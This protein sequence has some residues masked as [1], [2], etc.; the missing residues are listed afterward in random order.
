MLLLE[1]AGTVTL[2]T[3]DQ[4]GYSRSL[5]VRAEG[6]KFVVMLG[7]ETDADWTVR[8]YMNSSAQSENITI[9]GDIWSDRIVCNDV[10][11]VMAVFDEFFRAG[12]VS[13]DL[14]S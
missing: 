3:E 6:G 9:L 1:N 5:Q 14:L 4:H 13:E 11:L 10:S 8:T 7:I 12:D 2:D